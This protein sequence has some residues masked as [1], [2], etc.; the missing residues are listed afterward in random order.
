MD[1]VLKVLFLATEAAPFTKVGGL[2]DVANALPQ[3]LRSLGVDVRVIIPRYGSVHSEGVAFERV[4]GSIPVPVGSDHERVHLLQTMSGD[5]PVY[6]IWNDQYFSTREHVYG[7]NDDPQRFVFFSRAVIAA[8]EMLDWK[9]DVIH[10]NDWHTAPVPVWLDVYGRDDKAYKDIATLFTIHNLAYQGL[11]GRLLLA[12][13]K[14]KN[15]EHLSVEPPGQVNWLAQGIAHADLVST[16]SAT[17]ACEMLNGELDSSLV[18]LFQH[19]QDRFFGI[20]G[21]VDIVSWNPAED[22]VLP[23]TYDVDS[24]NMRT[25]NKTAF[26]REIHLPSDLNVPLLGIILR[27]DGTQD[28]DTALPAME[29]LLLNQDVQVVLLGIGDAHTENVARLQELRKRFPKNVAVQTK[30]DERLERRVYG[31]VDLFVM[32]GQIEPSNLSQM[33]AMHYGAIPVVRATCEG[34]DAVVDADVKPEHGTGFTF[35]EY[36][37]AALTDT[38]QRALVGYADESSWVA[39]QKRGMRRDVSWI[40]SARTYLDLYRRAIVLHGEA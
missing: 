34:A 3:A 15:L 40:T 7:F 35:A 31:S 20:L 1:K 9:P 39:M 33:T 23:Q 2:A 14:M 16:V 29:T 38:L 8:L 21:G 36:T 27:L 37:T 5:V 6:L 26:Q 19:K 11:C 4:G 13:G 32:P 25:V 30:F 22:S 12:F 17:Y 24:L 18:P 28:I 10:A